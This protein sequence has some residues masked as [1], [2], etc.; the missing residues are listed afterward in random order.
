ME[1]GVLRLLLRSLEFCFYHCLLSAVDRVSKL[2]RNT[3]MLEA[4]RLYRENIALKAQ[5]DVLEARLKREEAGV[6]PK[7]SLRERAAQVFAYLLTRENEPF[8]RYFLSAPISTIRRWSCRFRKRKYEPL[9]TG[10]R[11][12]VAPEI[13]ELILTLKRENGPWGQK[14]IHEELRRMGVRVCART[15][16]KVLEEG[17]FPPGPRRKMNFDRFFCSA[18]DVIWALDYFA[19]KT[20]KNKWVQVLMIIDIYTRE[21]IDIRVYDG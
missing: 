20:A 18:K 15:I 5:L 7:R 9:S 13:K 11:P 21:R 3:T 14:R 1:G 19:V 6:K 16:R 10:G 8:Q 4:A 17:G 12:G 2:P